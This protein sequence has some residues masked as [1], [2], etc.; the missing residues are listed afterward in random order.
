MIF[1]R[2]G[3]LFAAPWDSESHALGGDAAPILEGVRMESNTGLAQF[4]FSDDGTMVYVEGP[5]MSAAQPVWRDRNG[6]VTPLAL[7]RQVYGTFELAPDGNSLAIVIADARQ[8]IW[9]HDVARESLSRLTLE[10]INDFPVWIPDAQRVTFSKAPE[11]GGY[12]HVYWK[13]ADG[14]GEAERLLRGDFTAA[15]TSWLPDGSALAISNFQAGEVVRLSMEGR[16]VEPLL[17][18]SAIEWG[19][20]FSPDGRLMAYTSDESGRYEVYVQPYSPTGPKFQISTGGGEEPQ[21]SPRGDELFYR[22]GNEWMRA[23]ITTEPELEISRPQLLFRGNYVNVPGPSYDVSP[24]GERFLLLQPPHQD[25]PT[26]LHL[27]VNWFESF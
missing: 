13:D 6:A 19:L 24:D 2:S 7:R 1:S 5:T 15:P 10:G 16:E 18:S 26:E 17:Q 25:P 4:A 11:S 9:I 20:T 21:W 12:G 8:D 14:S 22:N 3:A 23:A 27:I